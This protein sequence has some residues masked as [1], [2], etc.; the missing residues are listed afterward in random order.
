[1]NHPQN[2]DI[3][4]LSLS[5]LQAN[6]GDDNG[7]GS[8]VGVQSELHSAYEPSSSVLSSSVGTIY[9]AAKH[10]SIRE[11]IIKQQEKHAQQHSGG[12]SAKYMPS[13]Q[14]SSSVSK[15]SMGERLPVVVPSVVLSEAAKERDTSFT[16]SASTDSAHGT[17]SAVSDLTSNDDCANSDRT[18]PAGYMT[19]HH[20][21]AHGL[22]SQLIHELDPSRM[23]DEE[24]LRVSSLF[25]AK[26]M[27]ISQ[28]IEKR[29]ALADK[30]ARPHSAVLSAVQ[31]MLGKDKPHHNPASPAPGKHAKAAKAPQEPA[32]DAKTLRS[33]VMRSKSGGS[34]S[35]SAFAKAP[36]AAPA[37][38]EPAEDEEL[39][40]AFSDSQRSSASSG[41][42]LPLT[43]HSDS[44]GGSHRAVSRGGAVPPNE[45]M[46]S[47]LSSSISPNM[48]PGAAP[49]FSRAATPS[50][51]LLTRSGSH[52][53]D[54]HHANPAQPSL[55]STPSLQ[56]SSSRPHSRLSC[57][58]NST[59]A[60]HEDPYLELTSRGYPSLRASEFNPY[61]APFAKPRRKASPPA[62]D[63]SFTSL[64]MAPEAGPSLTA[65]SLR[66]IADESKQGAVQLLC[67][68]AS[69]PL[70][71]SSSSLSLNSDGLESSGSLQDRDFDAIARAGGIDQLLSKHHPLNMSS[72]SE[73][74][75]SPFSAFDDRS[76]GS[77]SLNSNLSQSKQSQ[78]PHRQARHKRTTSS[79][80]C[81]ALRTSL[82]DVDLNCKPSASY[83]NGSSSMKKR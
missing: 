14:Y 31:S 16:S 27:R 52:S 25:S 65:S 76:Q 46:F 9:A 62:L 35:A 68:P 32:E 37:A 28:E 55:S 5:Q 71:R 63:C 43:P 74:V 48:S 29:P 17:E 13:A 12:H 36:R 24:L 33:H 72:R 82:A 59:G 41:P 42:R 50:H 40:R 22:P 18:A 79:S 58:S 7:D 70:Q 67:V 66:A 80:S 81:T 56:V 2:F 3:D 64:H 45:K 11:L 61:G 38:S 75:P 30:P 19:C 23:S 73:L 60:G 34:E 26:L 6:K 39:V 57:G 8:A 83:F 77:Q 53:P 69:R 21:P 1:M 44:L 47:L 15:S 49:Q 4:F 51:G 20:P 78:P 10:P 54:P